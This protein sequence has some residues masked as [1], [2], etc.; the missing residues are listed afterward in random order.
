M[1]V[2]HVPY[3]LQKLREAGIKVCV[4]TGD[5]LE[6]A[7][8]IGYSS[9]LLL[10]HFELVRIEATDP[11]GMDQALN[12]IIERYRIHFNSYS[13]LPTTPFAIV[14]DGPSL[15]L[16]L[17]AE[18]S[19]KFLSVLR[20]AVS[21]ICCR[22]SPLQKASVV[23]LVKKAGVAMDDDFIT[24]AV[25]DGANDCPMILKAH[26]GV[27]ISDGKE[28]MAAVLAS[29]F[30]IPRFA[31]LTRL[32]L[33]HGSHTYSR[34]SKLILFSFAKNIA[35]ALPNFWFA[36]VNGYSG[37]S[38]YWDFLFTWFNAVF[39]TAPIMT[40]AFTDEHA[41]DRALLRFP[42]LYKNGM[43]NQSFGWPNFLGWLLVG[44]WVSMCVYAFGLWIPQVAEVGPSGHTGGIWFAGVTG[45]GVL[46]FALTIQVSLFT[47][48]RNR[49][50]KANLLSLI[51]SPIIFFGFVSIYS[52][53]TTL[54]PDSAFIA[55]QLFTIPAFWLVLPVGT[56]TALLPN[57]TLKTIKHLWFPK[58]HH[59]LNQVMLAHN[60]MTHAMESAYK[61][62]QRSR[63]RRMPSSQNLG[64][65]RQLSRRLTRMGS[66]FAMHNIA[67][68]DADIGEEIVPVTASNMSSKSSK[69]ASSPVPEIAVA[70]AA[71]AESRDYFHAYEHAGDAVKPALIRDATR[72]R[73]DIESWAGGV[74]ALDDHHDVAPPNLVRTFSLMH[75]DTMSGFA[76][77][78]ESGHGVLV[79]DRNR[80]A[81]L[82]RRATRQAARANDHTH[83]KPQ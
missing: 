54:Y 3:C 11:A 80:E 12:G 30:S 66:S 25:G 13:A 35:L 23:D 1:I 20:A 77:S 68:H 33:V 59:I 79:N 34:M 27:G 32:L 73:I 44:T 16:A 56:I 72:A 5:K 57:A 83:I 15:S 52:A 19:D 50:R 78:Q 31:M 29:D 76:F 62:Q 21:A 7:V 28:G 53:L 82:K 51:A 36:F 65:N 40:L 14:I 58:A 61:E 22:C 42:G 4:C 17:Q 45:Y 64:V 24:L 71:A 63:V 39:T 55:Y 41:S 69:R 49:F 2:Q 38:L 9:G 81:A 74:H 43:N 37:Q 18:H 70:A 6:T 10:P 46:I 67:E 48:T 26:V 75:R 60:D 8:S 47:A